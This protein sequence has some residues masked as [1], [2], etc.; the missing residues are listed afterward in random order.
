MSIHTVPG[1]TPLDENRLAPDAR[2]IMI[3]GGTGVFGRRLADHL[4]ADVSARFVVTSRNNDKAQSLA[5]SLREKHANRQVDGIALDTASDLASAFQHIRPFLVIDASGPFQEYGYDVA[6]AALK[7]EAHCIDLADARNY[8][9]RYRNALDRSARRAGRIARCGASSTPALS[10]AV[11][12]ALTQAW[13]AVETVDI[14]ITPGGRSEVGRAVVEAVLSY[15]GRPVPVWRKGRLTSC[16]GWFGAARMEVPGLGV[17]RVA[18]VETFDAE[19]IGRRL[20]VTDRVAFYAGL[21]NLVEQFGM[22]FFAWLVKNGLRLSAPAMAPVLHAMRNITRFGMSD[23]GGMVVKVTGRNANNASTVAQ[24]SLLAEGGDGPYAP[25]LAASA[26]TRKILK[27]RIVPGAGLAAD[28]L[29]LDDIE[30]EMGRYA[31]SIRRTAH[32]R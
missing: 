4:A 14:C 11:V 7:A 10:F 21:E 6:E 5:A 8:L 3:I 24:W 17:R 29:T 22:E 18:P 31:I 2:T 25:T 32:I 23:K 26:L 20:S 12:D 13:T 1:L 30:A 9:A 15:A 28:V 19:L 27:G 16:P